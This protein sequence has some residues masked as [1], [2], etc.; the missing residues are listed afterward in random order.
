MLKS[1]VKEDRI[2]EER[3]RSKSARDGLLVVDKPA[4]WTSHDVVAKMRTVLGI[5][6]IGHVGTLDPDATGLLPLCVGQATRIVEYLLDVPKTYRVRMKLG[7][8]TDTEDAS[9]TILQSRDL[10]GLIEPQIDE[11]ISR[12]QGEILQTPPQYSAIKKNGRR[13]YKYARE[14]K[15]V[16]IEPRKVIIHEIYDRM[17][18]L[19]Y[20]SFYVRCSS[21]TYI[22]SLCRDIGD[23]LAVGAHMTDLRRTECV[24]FSEQD[25]YPL[26]ALIG[27]DQIEVLSKLVPMDLPLVHLEAVTVKDQAIPNVLHGRPLTQED[28][29][30]DTK[31]L[32][33][34][35]I[36]RIYDAQG[37][38]VAIGKGGRESLFPRKVFCRQSNN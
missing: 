27:M 13:L 26:S 8:E 17:L 35:A 37:T 4:G 22:R 33:I 38:F 12:F 3:P 2:R 7:E 28:L 19:P 36:I 14:G 32:K 21:G 18:D 1:L 29:V 25:A 10:D 31:E 20:I 6:K 30:E 5:R 11:M 15:K 16:Q 34:G 9:G 23:G 24:H